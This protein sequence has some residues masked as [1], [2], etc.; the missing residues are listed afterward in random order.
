MKKILKLTII[1]IIFLSLIG[2]TE[3]KEEKKVTIHRMEEKDIN[4]QIKEIIDKGNYII[5]DVRTKEEYNTSH[6]KGAI[7]IEYDKIDE[8]TKLDKD[9]TIMVYCKSGTRS[10]KAYNTLK[11]LGYDVFNMGAF[12][13]INL[14]KE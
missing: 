7:N 6:I 3:Q 4:T 5:V 14:E 9:K 8:N 11:N 2:C 1:S 12:E 13:N 10:T